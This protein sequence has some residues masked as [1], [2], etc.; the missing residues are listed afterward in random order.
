MNIAWQSSRVVDTAAGIQR[1][2]LMVETARLIGFDR[3]GT[4]LQ[5]AIDRQVTV[6]LDARRL[7]SDNGHI[8]F[9]SGN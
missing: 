8:R 7:I 3:T 6:L 5:A 2:D 1:K 9:A 4:D